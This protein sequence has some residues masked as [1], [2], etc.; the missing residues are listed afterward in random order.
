LR[1]AKKIRPTL[2]VSTKEIN[3]MSKSKSIKNRVQSRKKKT[4][5]KLLVQTARPRSSRT[6]ATALKVQPVRKVRKDFPVRQALKDIPVSP[7][8]TVSMV[9]M[10]PTVSTVP[11]LPQSSLALRTINSMLSGCYAL[12]TSCMQFSTRLR[13]KL[14]LL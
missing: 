8:V 4:A 9:K 3:A 12:M 1:A 13:T 6:A 7:V 10:A 2:T 11:S 14:G 5:P